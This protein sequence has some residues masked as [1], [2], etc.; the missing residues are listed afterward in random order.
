MGIGSLDKLYQVVTGGEINYDEADF[1]NEK[2]EDHHIDF[3]NLANQVVSGNPLTKQA[4][5]SSSPA[6]SGITDAQMTALQKYPMLVEMIGSD[7]ALAQILGDATN[8]YIVASV[9][10][11]SK[12]INKSA[13]ECKV[14]EGCL[15]QYFKYSDQAG[16]VKVSGRF[17]GGEYIHY[18][19]K[20][21]Q[22]MVL[23]KVGDK[24][25]KDISS[26]FNIE[27]NF[28]KV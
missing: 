28:V 10:Q 21:S 27:L 20:E 17:M 12:S 6:P 11:N 15:K 7:D 9:E 8:D 23:T 18:K 14:E 13:L 4:A 2:S 5:V 26:K 22:A 24:K 19:P 16:F 1:L 3:D 25:Y